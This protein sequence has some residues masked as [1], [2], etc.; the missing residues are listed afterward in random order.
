MMRGASRSALTL[1]QRHLLVT[2]EVT[3]KDRSYPWVLQWLTAQS[4]DRAVGALSQHVSVDTIVQRLASGKQQTRF[5][6]VP[7]PGRHVLR[8]QGHLLMV[9][10]QR[11]QQTVD[12]ST[13]QPWECV[14]LTA[15]GRSRTLFETF[16]KE[17]EEHAASKQE[18]TTTI[19][20]NWGTEWRPF[21]PPRR[22]RQ[23]HSVVLDE[24]I[25]EHILGDVEEFVR[26]PTWYA[27]RG[28]PYRR[29]YLL[30]GPPGSGKSSFVAA[31]AGELGYDICVLN[32][33]EAGLSDDRLT[34]ALTHAPPQALVLLE[35]IDAA[36]VEREAN[37]RNSRASF[38]TFSGLLNALDGVGAGEER[39]L[40]MTTN[41]IER[42]DPALIRPGRVDVIHEI[43]HA[44]EAQIRKLFRNFYPEAAGRVGE[45]S[46]ALKGC[47]LSM[48]LLQSYLMLHRNSADKACEQAAN[49]ARGL[50]EAAEANVPMQQH[51][52]QLAS[53]SPSHE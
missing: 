17:A 12:L 9:E 44:S 50:R 8:Y 46:D 1:A 24:G 18:K 38:V 22:R 30:H 11:E 23:L 27:D 3:S 21:G 39:L 25:S 26:S 31:L 13:G 4:R 10:R 47:K 15:M 33:S 6:F 5:E 35:D 7:C 53:R 29:G 49:F 36:F 34:H 14:K 51:M 16:L 45:F 2:L 37:P 43:G 20:S 48:A 40:F 52:S 28:I 41:H 19:Y 32:L 42:L